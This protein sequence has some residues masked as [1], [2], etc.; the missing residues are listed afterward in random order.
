MKNTHIEPTIIRTE[1]NEIAMKAREQKSID[2][3][4]T[5]V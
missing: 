3:Y 1:A 5:K 4:V 2:T